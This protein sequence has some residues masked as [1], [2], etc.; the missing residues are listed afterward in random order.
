M[1]WV[2]AGGVYLLIYGAR[3][4]F[5]P[6]M[7]YDEVYQVK[8]AQQIL[9]LSGYTETS[10]PPLAMLLMS[11]FIFLFG[12]LSWVWRLV[13]LFSGFGCLALIY[14][15][16]EAFVPSPCLSPTG[17]GEGEGRRTRVAFFA[18]VLFFLDGL[19]MSQARIGMLN[20]FMLFWMLLSV[21][22]LLQHSVLDVW[23]RRRAFFW[24]GICFGLG[25]ATRIVALSTPALLLV[26]YLLAWRQPA[27]RGPI[28]TDTFLY[29][30]LPA[31]LIYW[32]PFLI[33]PSIRGYG[34]SSL[35]AMQ[36]HFVDYHL[37]LTAGH[38]YASKWWGWPFLLRPIWYYYEAASTAGPKLVQGILS[39]GN[40][41]IFWGIPA[42]I[43]FVGVQF[44]KKRSRWPSLE[45]QFCFFAFILVGFFSEWLQWVPVRRVTFFHY[46]Y[47]ALPF[48]VMAIAVL[49]DRL[50]EWKPQGPRLV[51]IYLLCVFGM[52]LY[53]YPLLT[54]F[55][56]SESFFNQH[57]WFKSWI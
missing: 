7:H 56:I 19:A 23:T 21:Y 57:M 49:L 31:F 44:F 55:P 41:L 8:T 16:T 3:L 1:G 28:L 46:F 35:W 11:L 22:C 52:F 43:G 9:Q 25:V 14:K 33:L 4:G 30:F 15:I 17:R 47:T 18:A 38:T 32:I 50:W 39:I 37:H 20:A 26:P 27:K 29:L 24:S 34:F 54:G 53:W 36:K 10:H 45:S 5:P 13:S 48:A 6:T 2:L 40:P 42:G 51:L 12:N